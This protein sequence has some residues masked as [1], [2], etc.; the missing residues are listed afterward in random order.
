MEGAEKSMPNKGAEHIVIYLRSRKLYT[1]IISRNGRSSI[2]RAFE[3]FEKLR[4]ED[5]NLVITR[6]DPVPPK[7]SGDGIRF[8]AEWFG[9]KPEEIL[10]VGDYRYDIEAGNRAGAVTVLLRNPGTAV[11]FAVESRFQIS[12]LFELKRIVRQGL[13]VPSNPPLQ[14]FLLL[15]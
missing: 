14:P 4:M 6:N 3:N 2:K 5:F 12:R 9:I 7:P 13:P 11:S 15:G 10:V 8:A 1:G